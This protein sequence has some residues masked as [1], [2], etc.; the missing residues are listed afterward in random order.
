MDPTAVFD[1]LRQHGREEWA[2]ISG[3]PGGL[4]F[5]TFVIGLLAW[6]FSQHQRENQ[7][8]QIETLNARLKARDEEIGFLRRAR[9]ENLLDWFRRE[10]VREISRIRS[11]PQHPFNKGDKDA[12]ADMYRLYVISNIRDYG[13][14]K[15]QKQ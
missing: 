8:T 6:G 9:D 11:N 10:A 5:L 1:L 3:A 7:R 15:G 2:V 14:E 12:V 13:T 4:A